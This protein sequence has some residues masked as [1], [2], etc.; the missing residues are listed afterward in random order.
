MNFRYAR[1]VIWGFIISVV[2]FIASYL[3]YMSL[4][5]A[6]I[7]DSYVVVTRGSEAGFEIGSSKEEVLSKI[8]TLVQEGK[9]RTGVF[10]VRSRGDIKAH[11]KSEFIRY[12]YNAREAIVYGKSSDIWE[13]SASS[14]RWIVLWFE[15]N[16]LSKIENKYRFS[17]L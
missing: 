2:I 12:E 5:F 4:G 11:D 15:E 3:M 14:K 10:F 7:Y 8:S 16:K 13:V 6:G 9:L 17:R 1:G